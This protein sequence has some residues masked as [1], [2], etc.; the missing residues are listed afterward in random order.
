M[1]DQAADGRA[2]PGL[3]RSKPDEGEETARM[4]GW[5]CPSEGGWPFKV[6]GHPLAENTATP[7]PERRAFGGRTPQ[8]KA[9]PIHRER[10]EGAWAPP[11]GRLHLQVPKGTG[12]H[13]ERPGGTG[14]T[15]A[16]VA[17]KN[18]PRA[19][20]PPGPSAPG[21]RQDQDGPQGSRGG[22]LRGT[23]SL[24]LG[25]GRCPGAWRQLPS[26]LASLARPGPG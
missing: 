16:S 26:P 15:A 22:P 20:R 4:E 8:V 24:V 25:C 11:M 3:R 21:P 23:R 9:E 5:M 18:V 13:A 12:L 7:G 17:T 19:P 1:E 2:H 14:S 6:P 10:D